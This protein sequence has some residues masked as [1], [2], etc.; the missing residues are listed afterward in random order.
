MQPKHTALAVNDDIAGQVIRC[1]E[2]IARGKLRYTIT[3]L[4]RVISNLEN[5]HCFPDVDRRHKVGSGVAPLLKVMVSYYDVAKDTSGSGE[6]KHKHKITQDFYVRLTREELFRRANL[7]PATWRVA[8]KILK[9]AG[10]LELSYDKTRK[11]QGTLMYLR[12]NFDRLEE[13]NGAVQCLK[14][15]RREDWPHNQRVAPP[16][17]PPGYASKPGNNC[18]E[19]KAATAPGNGS[20][21]PRKSSRAKT[22]VVPG[23]EVIEVEVKPL[24]V[25][26]LVSSNSSCWNPTVAK[27][28]VVVNDN[29]QVQLNADLLLGDHPLALWFSPFFHSPHGALAFSSSDGDVIRVGD[30]QLRELP[31]PSGRGNS[32][33]EKEP[34]LH[35]VVDVIPE[36]GAA[37]APRS[38][39]PLVAP[40]GQDAKAVLPGA[41]V[42]GATRQP[43]PLPKSSFTGVNRRFAPIGFYDREANPG[44]TLVVIE[45]TVPTARH[46]APLDPELDGMLDLLCQHFGVKPDLFQIK[47]LQRLRSIPGYEALTFDRLALFIEINGQTHDYFPAWICD[48]SLDDFLE[49]GTWRIIANYVNLSSVQEADDCRYSLEAAFGENGF[50]AKAKVQ[51]EMPIEEFLP[52]LYV[53]IVT[54]AQDSTFGANDIP[55]D[56]LY[57]FLPRAVREG[58]EIPA[59]VMIQTRNALLNAPVFFRLTE[60]VCNWSGILGLTPAEI[61]SLNKQAGQM[62]RHARWIDYLAAAYEKTEPKF[63]GNRK[64]YFNDGLEDV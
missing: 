41:V 18:S 54:W 14:K 36:A 10:I 40:E 52:D 3:D 12:L 25:S 60:P 45:A 11:G 32:T 22:A 56:Y 47:K 20:T 2:F 62:V 31:G 34:K 5:P 9:Q 6:F 19:I 7:T 46:P 23:N 15:E 38:Q 53:D 8:R 26:D 49:P 28:T 37:S 16:Y 44:A 30:R 61:D 63:H 1:N 13:W 55:F 17:M 48:V 33:F 42:A 39:A 29:S 4:C 57:R 21:K 51:L 64:Y 50:V 27:P 35:T 43:G 24:T 59:K 58:F